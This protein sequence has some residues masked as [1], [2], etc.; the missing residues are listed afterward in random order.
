[1]GIALQQV[2]EECR[3]E[4]NRLIMAIAVRHPRHKPDGWYPG[5]SL[6]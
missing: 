5:S 2:T 6:F 3:A 4:E 1:M